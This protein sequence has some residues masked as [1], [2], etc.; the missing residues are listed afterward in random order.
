MFARIRQ[1]V[2]T[3]ETRS[4]GA[5]TLDVSRAAL[6]C[7]GEELKLRPKSYEVLRFLVE[8]PG[9][10]VTKTELTEAVWRD[11]FVTDDSLVQCIRDVRRALGDDPPRIIKTVAR[12]GYI[13]DAVV[14]TNQSTTSEKI[15]NLNRLPEEQ[16]ASR[17]ESS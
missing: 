12:R 7:N 8:N 10:I 13:F 15:A 11:S 5:F 2:P 17:K 6:L 4:F 3:N 1:R 9:R 14:E 16:T